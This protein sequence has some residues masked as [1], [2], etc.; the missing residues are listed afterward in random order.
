LPRSDVYERVAIMPS[1]MALVDF[2][3][4]RPAE[5]EDGICQAAL[6]CERKLLTQDASYEIPMPDPF[7][8]K[9]CADCVRACPLDAIRISRT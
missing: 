3:K 9:G 2:N 1:K 4:C 7:L 8:C 5:C 6:A